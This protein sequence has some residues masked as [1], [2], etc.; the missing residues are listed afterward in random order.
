MDKRPREDGLFASLSPP[1]YGNTKVTRELDWANPSPLS[2]FDRPRPV[3]TP[4]RWGMSVHRKGRA[5][6]SFAFQVE[7][8]YIC[9]SSL[10]N[11]FFCYCLGRGTMAITAAAYSF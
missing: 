11:Y 6:V 2:N 5:T 7:I 8:F 1:I 3:G 10:E 4:V 9:F